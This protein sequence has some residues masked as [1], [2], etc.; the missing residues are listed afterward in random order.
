MTISESDKD[1]LLKLIETRKN[2]IDEE[3]RK[4][5]NTKPS[6]KNVPSVQPWYNAKY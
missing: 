2:E 1:K 5:E 3:Q 6:P 4:R